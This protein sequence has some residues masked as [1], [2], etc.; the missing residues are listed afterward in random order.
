MV[1]IN[2]VL[3]QV[4]ACTIKNRHSERFKLDTICRIIEHNYYYVFSLTRFF[5]VAVTWKGVR[6]HVAKAAQGI[7]LSGYKVLP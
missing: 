1:N 5:N 7:S 2:I 3:S 6:S 4:D